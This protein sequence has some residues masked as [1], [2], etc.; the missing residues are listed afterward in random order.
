MVT[1]TFNNKIVNFNF[2]SQEMI[3]A[4]DEQIFE[5]EEKYGTINFD[6]FQYN[7]VSY[8]MFRDEYDTNEFTPQVVISGFENDDI[9]F[10][11]PNEVFDNL[12]E[13][14]RYSQ[15]MYRYLYFRMLNN[16]IDNF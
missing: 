8:K 13:C 10:E 2:L 3:D 4:F 14:A 12:P 16:E 15:E 7:R 6:L 5:F 11:L 1:L 9:I